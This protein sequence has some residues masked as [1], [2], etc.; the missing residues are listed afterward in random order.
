MINDDILAEVHD[1][2]NFYCSDICEKECKDCED[3]PVDDFIV[4]LGTQTETDEI[5]PVTSSTPN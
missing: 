2:S 1:L 3:C 4:W 5:E